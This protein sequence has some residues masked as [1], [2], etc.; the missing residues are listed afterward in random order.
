MGRG[1]RV[2]TR[3]VVAGTTCVRLQVLRV[4]ELSP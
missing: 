4:S 3:T 1:R 2:L